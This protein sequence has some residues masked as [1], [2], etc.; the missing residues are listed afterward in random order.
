MGNQTT[1]TSQY[2]AARLA[3]LL[4][5]IALATGLFAE[6]YVHFPSTLIVSGDP[7]K[8]AGNIIADERLYR[9]GIANNI[10]TFALVF[11][12]LFKGAN[13]PKMES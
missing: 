7:A 2:K 12:L 10:I 3:G 8:T 4:Y 5:L 13:I 6:F 1:I 11:W 9:F